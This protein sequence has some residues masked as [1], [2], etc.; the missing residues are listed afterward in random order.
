MKSFLFA[1]FFSLTLLSL[2]AQE[3]AAAG[4]PK[5]YKGVVVEYLNSSGYTYLRMKEES[6]E[7]WLAV[8][9]MDVKL[10]DTYYYQEGLFM[11]DVK[12]RDLDRTFK[13]VYFLEL[14]GTT[15]D[16]AFKKE[17][18]MPDHTGKAKTEKAVIK[19]E[20]CEGCIALSELFKS[21]ESFK[22]KTVRIRGQVVKFNDKI[23]GKNWI[24]LQDGSSYD[25]NFDL[26]ATSGE[27]VKTGDVITLEG[28]I[29]LNKDFGSGYFFKVILQEAKL[30][31]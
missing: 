5:V 1:I 10:G 18:A 4:S 14:V 17:I 24:H 22:G 23:M 15:P 27:T 30:V 6:G 26:T 8:P 20:P 25:N 29:E 7:K 19:V 28:K 12:S 21:P 9:R 11:R 3:P 13:T 16:G 2:Q 31:R